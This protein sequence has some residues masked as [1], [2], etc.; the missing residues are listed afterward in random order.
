V[1]REHVGGDATTVAITG[2]RDARGT[3]QHR[4]AQQVAVDELGA[5]RAPSQR[6]PRTPRLR[7]TAFETRA[8][9]AEAGRR[10]NR[11]SR[12]GAG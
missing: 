3:E 1:V 11:F 9:T 10:K 12:I 8:A 5:T 6:E 2:E 7:R 4:A